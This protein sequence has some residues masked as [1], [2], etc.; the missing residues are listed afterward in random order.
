M[1]NNTFKQIVNRLPL[2]GV[3]FAFPAWSSPPS[4]LQNQY[5]ESILQIDE[6]KSAAAAY[7]ADQIVSELLHPNAKRNEVTTHQQ[8][9]A[10]QLLENKASISELPAL[11]TIFFRSR[12][13]SLPEDPDLF[14][15]SLVQIIKIGRQ[16][17]EELKLF[18]EQDIGSVVVHVIFENINAQWADRYPQQYKGLLS[19]KKNN[20]TK[21][22][23][24]EAKI[25]TIAVSSW[26]QYQFTW[27]QGF[28]TENGSIAVELYRI[29]LFEL[30]QFWKEEPSL[31]RF[32]NEINAAWNLRDKPQSIV[33]PPKIKPGQVQNQ[34]Q[35][36]FAKISVTQFE[37][38]H[39]FPFVLLLFGIGFIGFLYIGRKY[40][41][42]WKFTVPFVVLMIIELALSFNMRP[43]VYERPFFQFHHWKVTPFTET[44]DYWATEG[45]YL[46][47]QIIAKNKSQKRVVIL[48]A[49]SAHGSNH[50][51]E[52]SFAGRLAAN[53][54]I[55]VI[56]LAIGGTTSNGLLHLFPYT[57]DL[58]P[59]LIIL[60][61]GHNEVAQFTQL[62]LYEQ[63]YLKTLKWQSLLWRSNIYSLLYKL[64][65]PEENH[66]SSFSG[67]PISKPQF[68]E[69]KELA[70]F[71]F[72]QNISLL[73][74][75]YQQKDIP[76][77]LMNP[78]T[79]YP[80]APQ[81]NT[82]HPTSI[83]EIQRSIDNSQ[84]STTITSNIRRLNLELS[85]KYG[86]AYI[87]LDQLFHI[88]SPDGTSANGLFWDELHPSNMGHE[89]IYLTIKD[90][91]S[92]KL[93]LEEE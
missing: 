54:D 74:D 90:W 28:K 82:D 56:N 73:L 22:H 48:G 16:H 89:W 11:W 58:S 92:K 30:I 1:R 23:T 25:N 2:L 24:V 72:K 63:Q 93:I 14:E 55:E 21:L 37:E 31:E 69:L 33:S 6:F 79:N 83:E 3:F 29:G 9:T 47:A 67:T 50:L 32:T 66:S 78:P 13:D 42:V 38:S 20:A 39:N 52:Q 41:F 65:K 91:V 81:E 43:L 35:P 76:V 51:M 45:S 15:R 62:A 71:N 4:P 40:S 77:L 57:I 5:Q 80:F 60:Y 49:S 59:D 70:H 26:E 8:I 12:F 86:T 34:P 61:Y 18:F 36:K 27:L 46:R 84:N 88:N 10:L 85:M 7:S 64:I 17:P 87:D 53:L 68:N 19:W 44:N 75:G